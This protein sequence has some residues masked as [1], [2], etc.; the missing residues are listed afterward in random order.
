MKPV[1]KLFLVAASFAFWF[2][3][4]ICHAQSLKAS[5]A[6]AHLG[7]SATV[8]GIVASEHTA[9]SS[10]GEPTFIN[11]DSAYPEQVFTILVWGSDRPSVGKLPELKSRMCAT[12]M[13]ESYHGVPQIVV[14]SG[15]QLG[16]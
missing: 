4:S 12:G 14:K 15:K 7:E 3:T 9:T 1:R 5:E 10:R 6:K 16:K 13:I 11:L 8:C 2:G